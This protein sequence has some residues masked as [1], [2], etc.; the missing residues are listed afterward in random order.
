MHGRLPLASTSQNTP[1]PI[2]W[3][4]RSSV[5]SLHLRLVLPGLSTRYCRL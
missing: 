1:R 5:K 4:L 2:D 3:P